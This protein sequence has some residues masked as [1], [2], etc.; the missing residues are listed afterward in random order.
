MHT[1]LPHCCT[2]H[3]VLL[4]VLPPVPQEVQR[5][6]IKGLPKIN[7]EKALNLLCACNAEQPQLSIAQA[8]AGCLFENCSA[9]L[10]SQVSPLASY[11]LPQAKRTC[12]YIITESR[13]TNP[14]TRTSQVSPLVLANFCVETACHHAPNVV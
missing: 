4:P 8:R 3:T 9:V 14:A 11:D 7:A 13:Y 10:T 2:L 5:T 6:D 12:K 1:V